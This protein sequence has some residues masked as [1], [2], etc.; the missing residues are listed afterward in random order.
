MIA[1]V[2]SSRGSA[3]PPVPNEIVG[4]ESSGGVVSISIA[5][6][7]FE[8]ST[9][10]VSSVERILKLYIPSA[11]GVNARRPGALFERVA[12]SVSS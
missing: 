3:I 10:P 6:E 5:E 4:P 1:P 2:E 12:S 8:G 9:S 7:Q 11:G